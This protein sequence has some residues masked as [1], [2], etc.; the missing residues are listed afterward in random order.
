MDLQP[1]LPLETW[2]TICDRLTGAHL[3][4]L[5]LAGRDLKTLWDAARNVLHRK[6]PHGYIVYE[7][8]HRTT[9]CGSHAL[10]V[11]GVDDVQSLHTAIRECLR[12]DGFLTRKGE[13]YSLYLREG[14]IW[15]SKR[16]VVHLSAFSNKNLAGLGIQPWSHL[17]VVVS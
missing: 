15:R 9:Y 4:C 7:V 11:R 17:E 2:E 10:R 3:K 16:G 6:A 8:Y 12:L 13:G 1:T 5:V 14:E